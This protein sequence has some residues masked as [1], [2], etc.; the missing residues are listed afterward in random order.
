[1]NYQLIKISLLTASLVAFPA[2]QAMIM[3]PKARPDKEEKSII[4]SAIS[5]AIAHS[6]L[7]QYKNN[8]KYSYLRLLPTEIVTYLKAYFIPNPQE[9][10]VLIDRNK[11]KETRILLEH[12]ANPDQKHGYWTPL[13]KAAENCHVNMVKLLLDNKADI[14]QTN[15]AKETALIL[16]AKATNSRGFDCVMALIDH[17]KQNNAL[18]IDDCKNALKNA[19]DRDIQEVLILKIDILLVKQV[20]DEVN[21]FLELQK[22]SKS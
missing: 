7:D 5:K 8:E 10:I 14:K 21:A 3:G 2:S 1:M 6:Y 18:T 22:T 12:G 4:N 17:N 11:L 19:T 16:A 13:T 15:L 20:L 9:L